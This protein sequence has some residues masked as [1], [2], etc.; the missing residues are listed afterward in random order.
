MKPIKSFLYPPE[1]TVDSVLSR[2][3]NPAEATIIT[4]FWQSGTTWLLESVVRASDA[5]SVFE[6]L[7]PHVGDYNK[8]FLERYR[9]SELKGDVKPGGI[10]PYCSD[11]RQFP[12][13]KTYLE[14]ALTGALPGYFTRQVRRSKKKG[15]Q[16]K[17]RMLRLMYR[18]QEACKTQ[19]VVKMVRSHLILP[20]IAEGINANIIHLR[21]DPRAVV[22][23]Y[24]R[25]DWTEWLR[26]ARLEDLLLNIDDGRESL[27]EEWESEIKKID[28]MGYT[29]RIAG[30][31]G[32][33]E[34]KVIDLHSVVQIQYENM[35][36]NKHEYLNSKCSQTGL[37][38]RKGD[39]EKE[40]ATSNRSS[41]MPIRDRL[42]SWERELTFEQ[43]KQIEKVMDMIG[44]ERTMVVQ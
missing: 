34:K 4:G 14:Q 2:F 15:E 24:Y 31:W 28:E 16:T 12:E 39:L 17:S 22:T 20:L 37:T 42:R 19:I 27:F 7:L 36:L 8:A 18:V 32:L 5:K 43:V 9:P 6:P 35:V 40:S 26:S 3:L 11:F 1:W 13:L 29:A 25:Q 10:I 38:F 44:M 23:S 30:Y 21:R 41:D 33:T